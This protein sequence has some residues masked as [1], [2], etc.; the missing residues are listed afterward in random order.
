MRYGN[1]W[2]YALPRFLRKGGSLRV[3]WS[4]RNEYIPH[5]AWIRHDNVLE[6]FVSEKEHDGKKVFSLAGEIEVIDPDGTSDEEAVMGGYISITP[7]RIDLT[8]H[9]AI[10]V[11]E[12][13]V[14]QSGIKETETKPKPSAR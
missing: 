3:C 8:E 7:L 2:F 4:P 1:C 5:C 6:E 12:N 9:K 10:P 11:F 13:W 14:Q